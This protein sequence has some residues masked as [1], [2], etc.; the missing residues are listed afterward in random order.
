MSEKVLLTEK[1]VT[2]AFRQIIEDFGADYVYRKRGLADS[3]FYVHKTPEGEAPGCIV[4]QLLHRLGVPLEVL[5]KREG[6]SAWA[7]F[8]GDVLFDEGQADSPVRLEGDYLARKIQL[9]QSAQDR[10]ETWGEAVRRG[11]FEV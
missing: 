4:G 3:C 10:G 1:N 8:Y 2:E 11:G 5:K 9:V 7:V 6:R